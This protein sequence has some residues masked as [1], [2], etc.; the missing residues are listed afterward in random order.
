[1]EN[2]ELKEQCVQLFLDGKNYTEIAKLTNHSRQY[3]TKLIKDDVRTKE[4]L[5][6]KIIK[7]SKLK[8]NSRCRV[9][10][11]TSFLGKIGIS[12]DYKKDDYVELTVDENSKIITIKKKE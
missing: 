8:N 2:E 9:S 3:I 6:K 1:M 7:V 4:Q 5:N 11:S 12:T 10:L